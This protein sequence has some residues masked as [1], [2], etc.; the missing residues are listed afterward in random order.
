MACLLPSPLAFGRG[1]V[2]GRGGRRC[3]S[4]CRRDGP[5]SAGEPESRPSGQGWSWAQLMRR[6]FA[7]NVLACPACGSR[8]RLI[9]LIFDPYTVRALLDSSAVTASLGDR[10][11]PAT[12]P[13]VVAGARAWARLLGPGRLLAWPGRFSSP[14]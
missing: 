7:L 4:T 14:R 8:L 11:P 13:A 3:W 9:A 1:G 12:P 10:A 6:A 5:P 2:G